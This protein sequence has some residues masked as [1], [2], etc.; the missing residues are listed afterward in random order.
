VACSQKVTVLPGASLNEPLKPENAYCSN[1]TVP[2]DPVTITGTANYKKRDLILSGLGSVSAARPIRF[3]EVAVLDASGNLLNCGETDINGDI[4]ID[5]Q[6]TSANIYVEVRSRGFNTQVKASIL[7]THQNVM[8]Y[9]LRSSSVVGDNNRSVGTFTAPATGTLEGGAF[10]ILDLI[11]RANVFLNTTTNNCNITFT[12]CPPLSVA[13]KVTVYWKKGFN[14]ATYF[15]FSANNTVSFYITGTSRLYLVGGVNGDT[16][17]TDTDHFDDHIILHEYGHFLEDSH[18]VSN[19]PGGAHDGDSLIDPRLAWSEGWASYFA[20]Q[21][22]GIPIYQDT[23]GNNSGV[24]SNLVYYNM[25]TNTSA[26]DPSAGPYVQQDGEGSFRE[27]AIARAL[28]DATDLDAGDTDNDGFE[29][30]FNEIWTI[31]AGSNG[32]ASSS[33]FFRFAGKFFSLHDSLAGRTDIKALLDTERIYDNPNSDFLA[34]Y[35]SPDTGDGCGAIAITPANGNTKSE[36]GSFE[37]SNQFASNDFY[38]I[39]HGGGT[40]DISLNHDGNQDLDIYLYTSDYLFG[41]TT[42]IKAKSD[43]TSGTTENINTSLAAGTYM[44]NVRL[45][46]KFNGTTLD[47]TTANYNLFVDSNRICP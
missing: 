38:E 2:V 8:Y 30:S 46:P 40:I 42:Y 6:R 15:G 29:G 3:A 36:D 33:I 9:S 16:D 44:L 11:Y 13:N 31:F 27:F 32:F 14:P 43:A 20:A 21:V 41:N 18:S 37:N 7:D 19:S 22:S 1:V 45:F 10:H 39:T 26:R 23:K 17:N 47:T 24:T 5:I 34:H 28:I 35:A 4:S 12:N 25:E